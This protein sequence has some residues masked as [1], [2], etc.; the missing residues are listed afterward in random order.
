MFDKHGLNKN[1][2]F[3][4]FIIRSGSISSFERLREHCQEIGAEV[5]SVHF[6]LSWV[7]MMD[8]RIQSEKLN[9]AKILEMMRYLEDNYGYEPLPDEVKALMAVRSNSLKELQAAINTGFE[10]N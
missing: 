7:E 5:P 4:E 9:T 10:L 2:I 1:Q 8:D 3:V 6:E